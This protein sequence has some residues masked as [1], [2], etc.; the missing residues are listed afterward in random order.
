SY[1]PTLLT[2]AGALVGACAL[3]ALLTLSLGR[4]AMGGALG[5]TRR[6][7]IPMW[8]LLVVMLALQLAAYLV[9]ETCETLAGGRPLTAPWLLGTLGWGV[10]GQA[11]VALLAALG[12]SWL[13]VRLDGAIAA[14]R[15]VIA[16]LRSLS[17]APVSLFGMALGPSRAPY[18][19]LASIC[20]A[21]L[22]KRG[23]P[24]DLL[25]Q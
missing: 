13:S 22:V 23:P 15:R 2:V 12:L 7:G 4:L 5:R 25:A 19:S 17:P 8:R 1:F 10:A 21:A 20:G 16:S 18:L 24:E 6:P 3:G 9:Q 11:P 14:I